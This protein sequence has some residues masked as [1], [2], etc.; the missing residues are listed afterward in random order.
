M[1]SLRSAAIPIL[2]PNSK[3]SPEIPIRFGIRFEIFYV[4]S[5][6]GISLLA[7][8]FK[9]YRLSVMINTKSDR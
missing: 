6:E 7:G 2:Y 1:Q 4:R 5:A 8:I 3:S 9:R